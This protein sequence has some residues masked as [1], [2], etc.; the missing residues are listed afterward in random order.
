MKP[1]LNLWLTP[2]STDPD[3]N[4]IAQ[5]S[6]SPLQTIREDFGTARLDQVISPEGQPV[7]DL[8]R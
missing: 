1:L 2:S 8:Y 7:R 5:V 4:G 3:F 6:S